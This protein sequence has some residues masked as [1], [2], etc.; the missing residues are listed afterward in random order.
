MTTDKKNQHYIPKFYLRN[1]SFE[2]NKKQIG[3]FDISSQYFF[4]K[5][6]LRH[7]GSET[8]FYGNDGEIEEILCQID[9]ETAIVIKNILES[10]QLPKKDSDSHRLLVAFIALTDLRNPSSIEKQMST[11]Q[12]VNS[13]MK[14]TGSEAHANKL[15]PQMTHRESVEFSLSRVNDLIDF[16]MD[17]NF[18][19]LINKTTNPFI[20]SDFPI[21]KYN[22][23]LE[24]KKWSQSKT[25]YG[26]VGL[27]IFLP[28]NSEIALMFFDTDIYKVGAKKQN[29]F[30]ITKVEGIESL[31]ILQFAN[32]YRTVYFNEKADENYLK[33]IY[34]KAKRLRKQNATQVNLGKFVK[35]DERLVNQI[36]PD[37]I[38]A[39]IV[40]NLDCDINL[41]IQGVK[42]R[43]TAVTYNPNVL[44]TQIRRKVREILAVLQ[45]SE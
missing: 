26:A 2:K 42:I 34:Q 20:T 35:K 16:M 1:F 43:S 19:L 9:Y 14:E 24:A 33:K 6:T 3:I 21:V 7:Q 37:S 41:Q 29:S 18:K 38:E 12:E 4:A 45:H 28:L 36:N 13:K 10:K 27:Q 11:F 25:G 31:N 30:E 32:C 22:Q 23:Y 15:L 44:G 5:A 17:L 39:I 40:K 8:F